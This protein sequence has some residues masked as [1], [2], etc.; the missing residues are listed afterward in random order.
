MQD[1]EDKKLYY[2]AIEKIVPKDDLFGLEP[3]R[4]TAFNNAVCQRGKN[5]GW[6][7]DKAEI[8]QIPVDPKANGTPRAPKT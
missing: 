1:T 2:H 8:L 7:G 4:L 5:Y 6:D 3:P